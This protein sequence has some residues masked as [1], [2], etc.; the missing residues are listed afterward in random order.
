MIS[1]VVCSQDDARFEAFA[2]KLGKHRSGVDSEVIRIPDASGMAE[3][4]NRGLKQSKGE[5]VIFCHDDIEFIGDDPLVNVEAHLRDFEVVGVAGTDRLTSARW[6]DAGPP[7][8]FGQVAHPDDSAL[9]VSLY[10]VPAKIV[11]EM[12]AMDGLFLAFR[13]EVAGRVGWD[14]QTF[15]GFHCYDVDTTFRAY[16]MGYRLGVAC[17]IPIIHRS[18]GSFGQEWMDAARAFVAKHGAHLSQPNQVAY[19]IGSVRVRNRVEA[20]EAMTPR[21]LER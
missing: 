1:I 2:A 18:G 4:Y 6:I 19:S 21:Y 15:R 13:R 16:R 20:L 7:H 5:S 8:I 9:I 10:G 17:D 11:G 14:E 12:V 3:G